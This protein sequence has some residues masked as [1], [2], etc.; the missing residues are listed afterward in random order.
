MKARFISVIILS[1]ITIWS[2]GSSDEDHQYTGIIEGTIV[3]IPALSGGQI[4]EMYVDLGDEIALNQPIALVDS[5]ELSYQRQ[6]LL[7]GLRELDVQTQIARTA[8]TRNQEDKSYIQKRFDRTLKLYKSNSVPEQ[9]YDDVRNQLEKINSAVTTSR[10]QIQSLSA[11][12]ESLQAQINLLNKKINDTLIKSPVNGIVTAKYYENGEAIP[13]MRPIVEVT[14]IN[15][16]DTKIYISANL[17]SQVSYEQEVQ[18]E[19][20]GVDQKMIGKVSW[21]SPKSEFTPKNILTPETRTTL[22]YAVKIT[23]DNQDKIL[24]HGMPVVIYL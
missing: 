9:N 2:C 6:Q 17:L 18:I 5:T 23:I 20:D 7:A 4:T 19:I 1:V 8:L 3:K 21:I 22:V 16:V 12:K 11:R 13:P 15:Q 10:Q 24:K 14:D